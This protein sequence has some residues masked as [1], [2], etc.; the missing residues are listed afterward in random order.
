MNN[1]LVCLMFARQFLKHSLSLS[2]SLSLSLLTFT[3]SYIYGERE[4]HIAIAFLPLNIQSLN[5]SLCQTWKHGPEYCLS[6]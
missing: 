2:F 4:G 3:P 6:G 1:A 5:P